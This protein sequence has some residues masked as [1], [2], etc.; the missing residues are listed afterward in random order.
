MSYDYNKLLGE[1]NNYRKK[2]YEN[3]VLIDLSLSNENNVN[4]NIVSYPSSIEHYLSSSTTTTTATTKPSRTQI[5]GVHLDSLNEAIELYGKLSSFCPLPPLLWLQYACDAGILLE[6]SLQTVNENNDDEESSLYHEQQKDVIETRIE[7]L[8]TGK[9]EFPGSKMLHRFYL[10]ELIRYYYCFYF[11]VSQNNEVDSNQQKEIEEIR[12][13]IIQ[14]FQDSIQWVCS[15]SHYADTAEDN[16]NDEDGKYN[17]LYSIWKTF[18]DFLQVTTLKDSYSSSETATQKKLLQQMYLH[19]SK[20]PFKTINDTLSQEIT[21]TTQHY[22]SHQKWDNEFFQTIEMNRREASTQISTIESHESNILE[23]MTREGIITSPI[24][25][26]SKGAPIDDSNTKAGNGG[27]VYAYS[28]LLV[29][30]PSR[31]SFHHHGFNSYYLM[32]FGGQNTASAFVKYAKHYA[33]HN[34]SDN[35]N[36]DYK[37][38]HTDNT[39]SMN[40]TLKSIRIYERG[41]SECPTVDNLWIAYLNFLIRI[42][43][44]SDSSKTPILTKNT[45]V[46]GDFL[47]KSS[48]RAVRNCPYSLPLWKLKM[49]IHSLL[50]SHPSNNS[51]S[52]TSSAVDA[53]I[54]NVDDLMKIAKDAIETKFLMPSPNAQFEILLEVS[55]VMNR[56]LLNTILSSP[57]NPPSKTDNNASDVKDS[58]EDKLDSI[59]D[60]ID[61]LREAFDSIHTY[62]NKSPIFPK[63]NTKKD[64]KKKG[65]NNHVIFSIKRN[66]LKERALLEA[67]VIYPMLQQ[68]PDL[69]LQEEEEEGNRV[70]TNTKKGSSMKAPESEAIKWFEKLVKFNPKNMLY[71]KDYIA[72]QKLVVSSVIPSLSPL[73]NSHNNGSKIKENKK[74]CNHHHHEAIRDLYQRAIHSITFTS[75]EDIPTTTTLDT[76]QSQLSELS[77]S[78]E[79]SLF[80]NILQT[81]ENDGEEDDATLLIAKDDFSL[82]GMLL[83]FHEYLSFEQ[84]F[85]TLENIRHAT[86]LI[87]RK[88]A[89]QKKFHQQNKNK[90]K[91]RNTRDNDSSNKNNSSGLKKRQWDEGAQSQSSLSQQDHQN[92]VEEKISSST[93]SN[94]LNNNKRVKVNHSPYEKQQQEEEA[95]EKKKEEASKIDLQE[96]PPSLENASSAPTT[97][98]VPDTILIGGLK[99]PVHP[100]TIRLSNLSLSTQDMDIVDFFQSTFPQHRIV[101]CRIL[102]EKHH[103][104]QQHHQQQQHN[105]IDTK[106]KSKG[107]AL[108]QFEEKESVQH[109]FSENKKNNN[110]SSSSSNNNVDHDGDHEMKDGDDDIIISFLLD[111][112]E[113]KLE[114]SHIPAV[115]SIV[116]PG[117]HKVNPKGQGKRSKY[118]ENRKKNKKNESHNF[119][120]GYE[121]E[122]AV[123]KTETMVEQKTKREEAENKESTIIMNDIGINPKTTEVTKTATSTK[124]PSSKKKKVTN[125]ALAFQPR[126]VTSRNQQKKK[127]KKINLSDTK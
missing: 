8:E 66:L 33:S 72:F 4:N 70:S 15:G 20:I 120:K 5:K 24:S 108:I 44:S 46:T 95:Q 37:K 115:S 9:N 45:V 58:D 36:G 63:N 119:S 84:N 29:L 85:G 100:Y 60:G 26:S 61:D 68:Y 13:R 43:S 41:I 76:D 74:S 78:L 57:S 80:A 40:N 98:L 94:N 92:N 118:N 121:N 3:C 109:I 113:L 48:E 25:S 17:D 86:Y 90:R 93:D 51:N 50:V 34:N 126:S 104:K 82:S 116:P 39:I 38:V 64:K 117:M 32:G 99:Y 56:Y 123:S 124:G 59:Q 97:V 67:N 30:R 16:T 122:E 91:N 96:K 31:S 62:I 69:L 107:V 35:D 23:Q 103:Q 75:F 1:I 22:F 49:N 111:G 11:L 77:Q 42:F 127:K 55:R 105:S 102:R 125:F 79:N 19:R 112:N 101:Y 14:S 83:F 71:W 27:G 21:F 110:M 52:N 73:H 47:Q 18:R 89:S 87:K 54:L 65:N 88:I 106:G 10:E 12:D 81:K 7:I 53:M 28:G 2:A 114:P 6:E